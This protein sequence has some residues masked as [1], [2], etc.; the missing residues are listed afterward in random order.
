MTAK[1]LKKELIIR[2]RN[3]LQSV[4][5]VNIADTFIIIAFTTAQLLGG[6]RQSLNYVFFAFFFFFL[7]AK[8]LKGREEK[9]YLFVLSNLIYVIYQTDRLFGKPDGPRLKSS[10]FPTCEKLCQ[11]G[12]V[13]RSVLHVLW[14]LIT[15]ASEP[16]LSRVC[17]QLSQTQYEG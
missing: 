15:P 3:G 16:R 11:S 17:N 8:R 12:H 4:L 7:F 2:G 10:V 9:N 6:S 1:K 13:K 5:K 14:V